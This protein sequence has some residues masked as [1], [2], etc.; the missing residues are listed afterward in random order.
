MKN[1]NIPDRGKK[2]RSTS[3]RIPPPDGAERA[4]A[5]QISPVALATA[6]ASAG[7]AF[8]Q[9]LHTVRRAD[10]LIA[11][12]AVLVLFNSALHLWLVPRAEY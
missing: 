5:S 8:I 3:T 11:G 6:A 4:T 10:G 12:L 9:R 7:L 2:R 1:N